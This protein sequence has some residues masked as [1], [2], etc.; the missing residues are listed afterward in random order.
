MSHLFK[1]L[2]LLGKELIR[3]IMPPLDLEFESQGTAPGASAKS[4]IN[5]RQAIVNSKEH[6]GQMPLPRV[7]V[8]TRRQQKHARASFIPGKRRRAV[9][10]T[11]YIACDLC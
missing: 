3:S 6:P 1:E 9:G 8:E 2:V 10:L 4:E 7:R 5:Y 11:H